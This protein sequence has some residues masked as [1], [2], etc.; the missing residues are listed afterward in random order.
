M[1]RKINVFRFQQ[2]RTRRTPQNINK[3][4]HSNENLYAMLE[5]LMKLHL[6]VNISVEIYHS[7]TTIMV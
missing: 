5:K 7:A 2:S 1:K 6:P 4:T 3:A